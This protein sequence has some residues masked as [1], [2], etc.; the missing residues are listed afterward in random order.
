MGAA[1][2]SSDS[3]RSRKDANNEPPPATTT[4]PNRSFRASTSHFEMVSKM[5]CGKP[6]RGW[7]GSFGSRQDGVLSEGNPNSLTKSGL[8]RI[9]TM[10][11]L[12]NNGI[13]KKD[14]IALSDGEMSLWEMSDSTLKNSVKKSDLLFGEATGRQY[15]NRWKLIQQLL[16]EQD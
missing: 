8:N 10:Q 3:R 1:S 13:S 16:S 7:F 14:A 5:I 11:I 2:C 4:P 12:R 9:Q 15:E 6:F